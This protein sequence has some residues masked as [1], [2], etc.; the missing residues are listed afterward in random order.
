MVR[1]LPG[2]TTPTAAADWVVNEVAAVQ[3]KEGR[4]GRRGKGSRGKERIDMTMDGTA[5]R[6]VKAV[7][8][9]G[10]KAVG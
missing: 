3:R 6:G 1:F 10:V 9:G 8:E 4:S 7:G 2:A 5:G